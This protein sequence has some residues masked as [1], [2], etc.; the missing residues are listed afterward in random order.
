MPWV[1]TARTAGVRRWGAAALDLAGSGAGYR[2]LS[3]QLLDDVDKALEAR[4][5]SFARYADDCNVYVRS[6]R[7]GERVLMAAVED[8]EVL[9]AVQLFC[10]TRAN[11]RHRAEA[12]KLFVHRRARRLPPLPVATPTCAR[13]PPAPNA[14]SDTMNNRTPCIG[15]TL[16]YR[17]SAPGPTSNT[18][19]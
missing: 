13:T 17:A 10:E 11:G 6:Q 4:G 3:R 12:G 19:P 16:A 7:A 18:T 2:A 15:D 1:R 5:Y 14:I 8:G 9:G